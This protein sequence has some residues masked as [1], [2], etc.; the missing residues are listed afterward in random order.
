MNKDLNKT[1]QTNA[2]NNSSNLFSLKLMTAVVAGALLIASC[3]GD[4]EA[5]RSSEEASNAQSLPIM[6]ESSKVDSAVN[7]SSLDSL[8]QQASIALFKARALSAT[9]YGL[10]A[11]DA[12]GD[13]S[14]KIELYDAGTELEM[15]KELLALSKKIAEFDAEQA[16][17]V[18][19]ENQKVMASLVRYFAGHPKFNIGYIDVWMG[20]SPFVVNQINGPLI[21]VPRYLQNDHRVTN[22]KEAKDYIERLAKFDQMVASITQKLEA[23]VA[24]GWIAPK[25]VLKG[26]TN[27]LEGFIKAKPEEHM[28]VTALR[29]KLANV[30]SIS[31]DAKKQLVEDAVR[32]VSEVIYPSYQAMLERTKSL[33]DKAPTDSGIWA[34]PNGE[35]YYQ[36][37][38]LQL[39]DSKKSAEQIHQIGIEEVARISKQMDSI[40]KAQGYKEGTVGER[41]IKLSEEPRFLYPDSDEGRKQ[42]LNDLNGY[43]AEINDKMAPLF[44][45]K[46]PYD[47][48]VR[49]FPVEIQDGAA[50]GQYTS[51]SLDGS[52]PGVYWINLR[53]MKANPKFSL[54]TLTYHEANPGHHWQVALNLAQD[55]LPFLR[56][57]APYNAYIEGWALYSELVAAELGMYENDPFSDLGRLQAEL[58]RAVRLVVDTGLHYKRWTREQAIEYMAAKTGSAESDVVAEIERYM[59]WPGQ[60]LGYKLGMIKILDLRDSAKSKLGDKFDLAE[61]HDLVLLGGAVPMNVLEQKVNSWIASK[62]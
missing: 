31:T 30:E 46:P 61:F 37:A 47:V 11:K 29:D 27:F 41:M 62:G 10:D 51:P 33:M 16:S 50:G 38:I 26:A 52:K 3:G 18:E 24:Q 45:T 28:L 8:Y 49:A 34:Q 48:E 17:S 13:Y 1:T 21:D 6:Q 5:S 43:I 36:D 58:F 7:V 15:R 55:D 2:I 42:L 54:K 53:D 20:L 59:A 9:A 56:R 39:G 22:E 35:E 40:L 12:G 23:D 57:I 32:T 25:V 44:K 60:A 4:K 19:K 14:T